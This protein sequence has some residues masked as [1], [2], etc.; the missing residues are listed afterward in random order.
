MTKPARL[1]RS[2]KF[3]EDCGAIRAHVTDSSGAQT[4]HGV[5]GKP[6]RDL[7]AVPNPVDDLV[8]RL[9]LRLVQLNRQ[10]QWAIKRALPDVALDLLTTLEAAV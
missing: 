3:T 5:A 6:E 4:P 10:T 8:R 7:F 2:A 9:R 1:A